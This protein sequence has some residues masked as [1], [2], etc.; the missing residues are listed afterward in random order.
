LDTNYWFPC[1]FHIADFSWKERL[2]GKYWE[3]PDQFGIQFVDANREKAAEKTHI[4]PNYI[5]NFTNA[6][7]Q[8]L[9]PTVLKV[10]DHIVN[11]KCTC[12]S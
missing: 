8:N 10:A 3:K 5:T 1:Y 2:Q 12:I 7:Q 6:G 9:F 11:I 4:C